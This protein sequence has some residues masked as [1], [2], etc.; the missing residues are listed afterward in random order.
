MRIP[1]TA[2]RIDILKRSVLWKRGEYFSDAQKVSIAKVLLA[3]R[4]QTSKILRTC[5]KRK[6]FF[7]IFE[8]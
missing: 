4:L 7:G 3:V 6:L 2:L 1:Y 5:I 8:S